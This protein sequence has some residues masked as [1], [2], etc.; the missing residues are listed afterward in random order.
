MLTSQR[1]SKG[2]RGMRALPQ[3]LLELRFF[4]STLPNCSLPTCYK[5]YI[6]KTN[7]EEMSYLNYESTGPKQMDAGLKSVKSKCQ[8]LVFSLFTLL[9]SPL[10]ILVPCFLIY[11]LF[12]R[13]LSFLFI[14]YC[15]EAKTDARA[16]SEERKKRG[17]A[18][19]R[20]RERERER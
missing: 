3:E 6:S 16:V 19:A 1:F 14:L 13:S 7:I 8:T 9:V 5:V 4:F 17:R 12:P 2:L 15:T 11:S 10:F 20:A 18:R